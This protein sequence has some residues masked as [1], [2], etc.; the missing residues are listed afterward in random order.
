MGEDT[1]G[2][3]S[4][5]RVSVDEAARALGLTVDAIRKRVQRG[6]IP[7]EK[8]QA[9]RVRIILDAP[10]TLQDEHPDT[11]GLAQSELVEELRDRIRSL[12]RHLDEEREARTEERRRYDTV[13]AQLSQASA[14]QARTIRE[15]EPP[16]ESPTPPAEASEGAGPRSATGETHAATEQPSGAT[17][18][19]KPEERRP[20]V[21]RWELWFLIALGTLALLAALALGYFLTSG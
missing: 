8:D 17:E 3:S 7:H 16:R 2:H 10:E 6:T 12:E 1:R 15:L 19:Q 4:G 11:T 9:G 5:R 14:E 20:A 13:I 21:S 18:E